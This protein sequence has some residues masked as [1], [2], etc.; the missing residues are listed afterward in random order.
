MVGRHQNWISSRAVSRVI[1][2]R[3][4]AQF[5]RFLPISLIYRRYS[6][7]CAQN[8]FARR[9]PYDMDSTAY[10]RSKPPRRGGRLMR[11]EWYR[12][13]KILEVC[14]STNP[15]DRPTASEL[16]ARLLNIF[17]SFRNESGFQCIQL[18]GVV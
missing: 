2:S 5:T 16:E 12:L 9:P 15:S 14:W 18:Y 13:W 10:D 6:R 4:H 11:M 7:I 17:E 3:L 1:L 8:T